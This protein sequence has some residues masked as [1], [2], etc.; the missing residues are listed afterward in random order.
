[1]PS[2]VHNAKNEGGTIML[3]R[4]L[5]AHVGLITS[6]ILVTN[7]KESQTSQDISW[8]TSADN[9]ILDPIITPL[10]EFKEVFVVVVVVIIFLLIFL[11]YVWKRR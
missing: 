1:M 7:R 9:G 10:V 3:A 5:N 8:L 2:H 4:G 6:R 11:F